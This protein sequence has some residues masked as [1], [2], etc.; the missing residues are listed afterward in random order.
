MSLVR[1]RRLH[2]L[3]DLK[4]RAYSDAISSVL[5]AVSAVLAGA[6]VP[7]SA[8]AQTGGPIKIGYSMALTGGLGPNGKSALLAHKI[9]EEEANA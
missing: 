5:F 8:A 2:M 7:F 1:P 4:I 6:F 9:W 3:L